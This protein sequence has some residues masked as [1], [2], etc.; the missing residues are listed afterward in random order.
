M[1]PPIKILIKEAVEVTLAGVTAST[2]G[3]LQ[4][5]GAKGL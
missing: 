5:N 3:R 4:R 2:S 1:T